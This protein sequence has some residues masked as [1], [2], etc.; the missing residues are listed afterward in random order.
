[1]LPKAIDESIWCEDAG[2]LGDRLPDLGD[3]DQP[4]PLQEVY[5]EHC[6][7]NSKKKNF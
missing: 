3:L 5:E 7:K 4:F 2:Y 6:N 1:M